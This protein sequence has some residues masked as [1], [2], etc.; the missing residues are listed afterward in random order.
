MKAI[1]ID[2]V[3]KT[4]TELNLDPQKNML[5]Q[6]YKALDVNMVEVAHYITDHDSILVDEEGLF[7]PCD[8]FFVYEGAHQP[9]AGKGLV[10]GVNEDGETVACDITVK[11]VESKVKFMSRNEVIKLL[12]SSQVAG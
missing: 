1:L 8:H 6:W 4:V 9:F 12:E 5:T 10:V 3:N 11:E 7:K 2:S